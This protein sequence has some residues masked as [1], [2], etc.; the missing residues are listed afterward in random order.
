MRLKR[1]VVV[2]YYTGVIVKRFRT[3]K[4]AR[5][6]MDKPLKIMG[7]DFDK[8]SFMEI[9]ILSDAESNLAQPRFA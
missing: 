8:H 7:I 5:R 1:Y 4:R 6:W 3:L 2:N 9:V